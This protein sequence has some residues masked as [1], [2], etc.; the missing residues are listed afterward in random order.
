MFCIETGWPPWELFVTVIMHSGMFSAPIS[1]MN[2]FQ[3]RGV[4]VPLEI[5][6]AVGVDAL[7]R[8]QIDRH[9]AGELDVRAG[10]VEMGVV[11]H[12][13]ARP[14][15]DREQNLLR[16]AA[17]VR[18]DDILE[19]G[20]FLDLIE[21]A[22][23]APRPRIRL[24]AP[25]DAGPLVGA[26][27]RGAAVGQQID[28]H[29]LGRHHKEVISAFFQ[30]FFS[31]LQGS[32]L[33]RLDRLDLERLDNGFHGHNMGASECMELWQPVW[34][35]HFSMPRLATISLRGLSDLRPRRVILRRL[36]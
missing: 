28:Q 22:I 14:A 27:R 20:Q 5:G 19:S 23:E 29:V 35:R 18:R 11:G 31:L 21:K 6:D 12:V 34:R 24:I 36:S 17:L 9:G 7:G 1:R 8:G 30:D 4:H 2:S 32:E 13:L 25:H 33:D 10:R 16:R 3:R 15:H 26:H